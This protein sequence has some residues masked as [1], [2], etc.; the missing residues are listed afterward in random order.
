MITSSDISRCAY[1]DTSE[2]EKMIQKKS[3]NKKLMKSSFLGITNGGQFCYNV[4]YPDGQ[5]IKKSKLFVWIN[6]ADKLVVD[7]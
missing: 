5:E 7:F 3:V 4:V 1:I 2:L 6:E